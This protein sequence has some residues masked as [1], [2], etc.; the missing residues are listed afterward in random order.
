M[1]HLGHPF[2]QERFLL[3][4]FLGF[5]SFSFL[6]AANVYT[7]NNFLL[8]VNKPSSV[9]LLS[10]SPLS[11]YSWS[12]SYQ[13]RRRPAVPFRYAY[14]A[15][16]DL[17]VCVCRKR[18]HMRFTWIFLTL[19]LLLLLL[20]LPFATPLQLLPCCLCRA[21]VVSVNWRILKTHKIALCLPFHF[22]FST[23]QFSLPACLPAAFPPFIRF[24]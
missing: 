2:L 23:A 16:F 18:A 24:V 1:R 20:L 14:T 21:F 11:L 3:S 10:F 7:L 13:P 8:V 15:V 9:L 12:S 5:F 6:Y 17:C 4:L 19:F 22:G